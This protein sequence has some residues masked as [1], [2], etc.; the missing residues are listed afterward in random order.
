MIIIDAHEDLAYSALTFGRDYTQSA[1]FIRQSEKGTFIPSVNGHAMLGWKEYQQ[2]KIAIIFATLFIT[3]ERYKEGEWDVISYRT[4]EQAHKLY[5]KEIDYYQKLCEENPQKFQLVSNRLNLQTVLSCWE[6]KQNSEMGNTTT[7][8]TGLVMLMESAEG[9]RHPRE[10]EEYWEAG[11]R[12]VGPVWAGGRFCGGSM[13][14]ER[15]TKEGYE[16]LETM[17]TLGFALD[18]T[19][20]NEISTLQA[21]DIYEGVVI[22]S[23]SNARALIR[24][25][26]G[27]Y[28]I[29]DRK[30][31]RHLSDL[32][33]R[34]LIERDGVIGVLPYNRFLRPGWAEQDGRHLVTLKDLA[35]HIDHICQIAGNA[36]HVGIGTDFDGGFGWPAIPLEMETIAD[37]QKLSG[38]LAEKGYQFEDIA[39]ILG[40]NWQRILEKVLPES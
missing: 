14:G 5:W 3:P 35:A 36:R 13:E 12:I 4:P 18:V 10:M 19:H 25:N 26:G 9:I 40:G 39:A 33:I 15:F 30:G 11:V 7:C 31:E 22:A 38:V 23:H 34:R 28:H 17:A 32:A 29:T 21:L 27:E 2:G 37:L 20:M 1:A 6:Q 16:L 24:Y 8:P